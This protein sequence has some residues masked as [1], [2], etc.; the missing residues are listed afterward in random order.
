M[1]PDDSW[2]LHGPGSKRSGAFAFYR[3]IFSEVA[4]LGRHLTVNQAMRRFESCPRSQSVLASGVTGN[5][6]GSEPKDSGIVS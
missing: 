3:R 6:F 4:K 2:E 5:T 1:R